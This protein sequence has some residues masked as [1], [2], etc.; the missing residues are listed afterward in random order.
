[1][2]E[3]RALEF[4]RPGEQ[5]NALLAPIACG[6]VFRLIL[7]K[8]DQ[9]VEKLAVL[10]ANPCD[11]VLRPDG[12]RKLRRGWLV[13]VVKKTKAEVA[14]LERAEMTRPPIGYVLNTGQHDGDIAY[15]F[16]NSNVE[17]VDLDALDLCWTNV[18][19]FGSLEPTEAQAAFGFVLPAQQKRLEHLAR[20][21]N[22]DKFATMELWGYRVALTRESAT[23][24]QIGALTSAAK[25]SYPIAREWRLGGEFASAVLLALSHSIAR[26]VF[27]H[28]YLRLE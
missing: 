11:L 7:E 22:D 1:L 19:G 14:E 3:L 25:V 16:R 5:L 28:D 17:S 26:P 27:G 13:E 2:R 8:N 18:S 20:R 24:A 6:D 9:T 12:V 21:V 15:L 4:E 10:L 23:P